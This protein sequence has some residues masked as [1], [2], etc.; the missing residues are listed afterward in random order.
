MYKEEE[1][2][3]TEMM[4][5]Y[6]NIA[7]PDQVDGYIKAGIQQ[8]TKR[9]VRTR[10]TVFSTLTAAVLVIFLI[11]SIRISPVFASYVSQVPGLSSL[12]T[13]VQGD[14]GLESAV[15]N[16][17]VQVVDQSE[18]H[19]GITFN[20]SEV[21]ADESRLLIFYT[22]ESDK[23]IDSLTLS[24]VRINNEA[25]ESVVG[26]LGFDYMIEG[27]AKGEKKAGKLDVGFKEGMDLPEKIELKTN[28]EVGLSGEK[29]SLLDHTWEINFPVDEKK[30]FGN[31]KVYTLNETVEVENQEITIKE[32]TVFPTRIA[33]H[34]KFD[35]QNTKRLFSFDDLAIVNGNGE[36]WAS[37][38]NGVNAELIS[39]NEQILYLESNFFS[40]P[41]EM[42][43]T[44]SSI[45]AL[46]KDRVSVVVD[47]KQNKLL[48]RP[49]QQLTLSDKST[50]TNLVFSLTRPSN[51]DDHTTYEIFD[52]MYYDHNGEKN[53]FKNGQLIS[54]IGDDNTIEISLPIEAGGL[55]GPITLKLT[56][57]PQR[58]SEDIKM[59]IK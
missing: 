32:V 56:D 10:T 29:R 47:L 59:P 1:K 41:E 19:N 6:E 20:V 16:S 55:D 31:E 38:S 30:F 58:I 3:L 17:F 40:K 28:I 5:R 15:E 39:K 49:S 21:I 25:G 34:V 36:E 12:V 50:S 53:E 46:D 14:K 26:S 2:K 52:Q 27:I 35:A 42:Y 4:D 44:F 24:D 45:R 37:V 51:L 43:V 33:V 18:K 23:D 54:H 11:S 22:I 13:L 48:K 57:Y 8:A 9:K 7:V